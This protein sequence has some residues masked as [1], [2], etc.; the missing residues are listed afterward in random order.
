[1]PNISPVNYPKVSGN[2]E[3]INSNNY[4]IPNQQ[5]SA[6]NAGAFNK[7][8][9]SQTA[10]YINP[11]NSNNSGMNIASEATKAAGAAEDFVAQGMYAPLVGKMLEKALGGRDNPMFGALAREVARDIAR[12]MPQD[13]GAVYRAFEEIM[14]DKFKHRNRQPSAQ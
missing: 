1:M 9:Q 2:Y 12:L 10:A 5:V 3:T 7:V 8:L 4:K 6:S 14:S 11:K 13:E